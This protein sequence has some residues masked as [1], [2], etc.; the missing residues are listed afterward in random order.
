LALVE[1]LAAV[2]ERLRR[3]S[4]VLRAALE[5]LEAEELAKPNRPTK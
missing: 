3:L 5:E 2:H 4:L 1:E